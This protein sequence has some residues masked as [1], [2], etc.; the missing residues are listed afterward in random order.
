MASSEPR[1]AHLSRRPGFC[2]AERTHDLPAKPRNVPDTGPRHRRT[3]L[4]LST[5]PGGP[6][7]DG[8]MGNLGGLQGGART[9]ECRFRAAGSGRGRA[10]IRVGPLRLP[11]TTPAP[12]RVGPLRL[13]DAGR[14]RAVRG[15]ESS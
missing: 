12:I 11:R 15:P 6:T 14:V 10:P 5:R 3:S 9:P 2:I 13:P 8:N 4:T 1:H 7:A